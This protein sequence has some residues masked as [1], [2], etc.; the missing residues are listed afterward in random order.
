MSKFD[1]S[2][3]RLA[4]SL[5]EIDASKKRTITID[6]VM[7]KSKIIGTVGVPT[8]IVSTTRATTDVPVAKP[9]T[10]IGT[11]RIGYVSKEKHAAKKS[12]ISKLLRGKKF[13]L[14]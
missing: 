7:T 9:K 4:N 3:A 12:K 8:K 6:A 2:V 5:A 14:S 13:D 10:T 1:A 11:G